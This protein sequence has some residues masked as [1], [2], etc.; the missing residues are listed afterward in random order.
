MKATVLI[1]DDDP[2]LRRA[3]AD[4]LAFWGHEADAVADGTAGLASA[5]AR[6]YDII[7]L[8]LSMPGPS[9][10]D[11]LAE[12]KRR[13]IDSD[14]IVLTA[15]GTVEV[16]VAAIRLGAADFL[17]KPADFDL[18]EAAIARLLDRRRL[19]HANRALVERREEETGAVLGES[20][21]MRAI[22]ETIHQVAPTN[23]TVLIVG[24]SGVGKHVVAEAIHRESP[25]AAGPFVYVNMVAL[26]DELAESILFGHEKG[27]FTGA[28]ARKDGK[29][30]A[31]A[32]GTIFLDEIGD[33]TPALQ[34]KLLHFLE[35]MEFERV[36][37]TRTLRVDARV[38]AATN[39]NLEEA[40]QKGAFR[41][42]LY[43]RL[44]VIRIEV[45]PLRER[46]E[47]IP[48]LT[49]RFL[50][51]HGRRVG[52]WPLRLAPQ[53][54]EI[55]QSFDWPGNVRQLNNCIERIVV[56][57]RTDTLTPD[58]LPP[59]LFAEAAAEPRGLEALPLKEAMTEYKRRHIRDALARAGGNQTRAAAM[60][61]LQRTH[62]NRLL[63]ELSIDAARSAP[64]SEPGTASEGDTP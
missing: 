3:L 34:T 13:N 44:N 14:V 50:E 20:R 4:R 60:L 43:Y 37:G 11:V 15:H 32:G 47:D 45:P 55:F 17:Q 61:G 9:G 26:P 5:A 38:I 33:I 52:S 42:D 63:K 24:E 48:V 30:E 8:D 16:A 53:I 31:A 6:G 64:S 56:L 41:S 35:T 39:R 19:L 59:E 58:L 22:Q 51:R 23:S 28:T 57:A 27:S 62:L 54:A 21:A 18:L 10:L 36:G 2:A 40:I 29:L 12:L 49:A 7:L 46:R 25:R 1:V